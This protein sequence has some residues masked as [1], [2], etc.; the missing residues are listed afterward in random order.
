MPELRLTQEQLE[1]LS[2]KPRSRYR[3]ARHAAIAQIAYELG[4]IKSDTQWGFRDA[5]NHWNK[6]IDWLD[7]NYPLWRGYPVEYVPSDREVA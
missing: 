1:I 7:V 6:T 5:P 2:R 4:F 3:K